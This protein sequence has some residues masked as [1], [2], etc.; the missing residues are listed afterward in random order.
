MKTWQNKKKERNAGRGKHCE[1]L[2]TL[3]REEER[4][5]SA[6]FRLVEVLAIT[7]QDKC[8]SVIH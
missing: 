2:E 1:T 7:S 8:S 3:W 5:R 4:K 6:D